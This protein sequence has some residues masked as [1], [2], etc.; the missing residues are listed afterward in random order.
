MSVFPPDDI[1][2]YDTETASYID[3]IFLKGLKFKNKYLPYIA[4]MNF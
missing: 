4:D 3:D 2:G 1:T